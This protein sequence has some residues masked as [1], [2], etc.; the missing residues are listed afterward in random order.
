[1]LILAILVIGIAAGWIAELVVNR[2]QKVNWTEGHSKPTEARQRQIE[3][4]LGAMF[5]V[6]SLTEKHVGEFVRAMRVK[7]DKAT[8]IN[9]KVGLL[10]AAIDR[11]FSFFKPAPHVQNGGRIG[12]SF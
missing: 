8:T 7:G 2:G 5:L 1:M 4:I 10:K 6:Q 3:K 11:F 9:R 12:N